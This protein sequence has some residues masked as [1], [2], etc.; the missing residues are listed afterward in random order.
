MYQ[1][2]LKFIN[3][4]T[5][6]LEPLSFL[7]PLTAIVLYAVVQQEMLQSLRWEPMLPSLWVISLEIVPLKLSFMLPLLLLLLEFQSLMDRPTNTMSKQTDLLWLL[8]LVLS[9]FNVNLVLAALLPSF[10]FL[11]FCSSSIFSFHY[12]NNSIIKRREQLILIKKKKKKKKILR[13]LYY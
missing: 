8:A 7:F 10:L 13:K 2:P 3:F 6:F 11:F 1:T 12:F 4:P 5:F 9:L